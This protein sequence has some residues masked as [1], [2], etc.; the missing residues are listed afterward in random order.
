MEDQPSSNATKSS[1]DGSSEGLLVE[2]RGESAAEIGLKRT[3]GVPGGV[4]LLVGTII[5]AG[6]FATPRFIMMYAG[7]V[8]LNLVIWS[9]CGI[10]A[11]CGGLCYLELGTL[12]PRSG[13]EYT[14]ILEAF[15]PLPAFLYSW[16]HVIWLKPA[17][18]S[19]LLTFGTYVL[20][21]FYPGCSEKKE[22]MPYIKLI[23]ALAVGKLHLRLKT[24]MCHNIIRLIIDFISYS[25]YN[26]CQLCKC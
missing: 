11:L 16:L 20:E 1:S 8:G 26:V 24:L 10:F 4:S 2:S 12:I 6:I 13:A 25:N 14:Y 15:G 3:L 21:P 22:F 17:G 19:I 5:G 9:V 7:S 23:A 18:V